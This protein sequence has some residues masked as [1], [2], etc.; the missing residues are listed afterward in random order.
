M[1]S[2]DHL[3]TALRDEISEL[4][5]LLC[6]RETEL[7][8]LKR[9]VEKLGEENRAFRAI[10]R[11]RGIPWE[12]EIAAE[13]HRRCFARMRNEHQTGN[14]AMWRMFCAW[15]RLSRGSQHILAPSC[16]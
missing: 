7:S 6:C 16:A 3:E 1:T 13:F 11:K 5:A 15:L 12:E 14:A 4:T 9:R 8:E 2:A 10:A